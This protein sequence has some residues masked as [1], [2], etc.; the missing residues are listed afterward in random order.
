[1]ADL[2]P[3]SS[4]TA[5]DALHLGRR[6][7]FGLT[8]E[9]AAAL[10]SQDPT[11]AIE[12]WVDGTG[13]DTAAFDSVWADRADPVWL[14]AVGAAAGGTDVPA[15]NQ[16]HAYLVTGADAWRNSLSRAQASWA[17]RMQYHPYAFA[18]RMALFFT[19]LF[20]TGYTKVGN[21]A[22]MLQQIETLRQGATGKFDDLLV[23]VSKDPAMALWLDSVLNNAAGSSVPNENYA[24]EVM[25]LYSLGADNGYNQTDITQLALALSGWSFVVDPADLSV[26]PADPGNKV[27]ARGR[28]QVYDGSTLAASAYRYNNLDTLAT[29]VP[30]RHVNAAR[31]SAIAFLG[32][33]LDVSVPAQGGWAAGENALRSIFTAR[34]S[35]AAQFLA[36]RLVLHFV[37]PLARLGPT[38]VSDVAALIQANAFDLRATLKTLLKSRFFFDPANRFALVE[39]PVSW[40]VR[41]ARML[42]MDLATADAGSMTAKGFPSWATIAPFF[43][44]GGMKLLD[45]NGPNGWKED[46]AWL[47]SNT[48]RYRTRLASALALGET[49]SQGGSNVP[50]VPSDPASWFPVAPANPLDVFDRLVALLQPSPVPAA[51]RDAWIADLWPTG[52]TFTWDAAGQKKARELAFVILCSPESQV[53]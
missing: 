10:A 9:A 45:P 24:R 30:N 14:S 16:A 18:E 38:D 6:A 25:E 3:I 29:T 8:P 46:V 33:T 52:T 17:F 2:T 39:G 44:Q 20:A 4:W 48:V 15:V 42:G 13:L 36:S 40:V 50:L 12:A 28:F 5:D 31:G 51:V 11:T 23:A 22:L 7:G 43:E 49:Y 19:N 32:Q 27:A 35:N 37:S 1:M 53:Y 21:A 26:S 47:N 34:A 41:A